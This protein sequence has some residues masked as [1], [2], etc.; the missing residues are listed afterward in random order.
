MNY[1]GGILDDGC[2]MYSLLTYIVDTLHYRLGAWFSGRPSQ[3]AVLDHL[4]WHVSVQNDGWA[5]AT[6]TLYPEMRI[7]E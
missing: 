2:E 3:T 1:A 4:S 7:A 5:I 6:D